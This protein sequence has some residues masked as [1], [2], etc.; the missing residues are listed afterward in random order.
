MS[1]SNEVEETIEKLEETRKLALRAVASFLAVVLILGATAGRAYFLFSNRPEA[2]KKEVE[3]I[4]DPVVAVSEVLEAQ[5]GVEILAEGIVESQR[6]VTLTAEVSGKIIEVSPQLVPGGR[7]REGEVL[8]RLE[9]ADYSASLEQAKSAVAD[10][11]LAI[12]QEIAK[13][14]QALRDWETLGKGE[15]SSLLSRKPQLASARARLESVKAEAQRAAR[16]LERT[17]LRAPFDAVVR[18]ESVEVGAVLAPGTQLATL[19]SERSLEVELPLRLEDYAL[20]QRDEQGQV[21]GSVVLLGSLGSREVRWPARILRTTGEV[22]RGALTAGVVV[23]VEAAD[24]E[25]EFRLPP[26]GLFVKAKLEGQALSKAV[27]VP[28]E[29]IRD[30]SRVAVATEKGLLEFRDLEVVRSSATEVLVTAGVK[31]GEQV[32]LTRLSSPSEGMRVAVNEEEQVEEEAPE[33]EGK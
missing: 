29:A 3:A 27:V 16:N 13:R 26:P 22:E 12:E 14:D 28:R 17:V 25:G 8:A 33:K 5:G 15:P 21:Q 10:A 2:K 20:L 11:E 4:V 18:Q 9:T 30:G 1:D 32:I 6:V 24:G 23:G 7:V 19:F 31:A